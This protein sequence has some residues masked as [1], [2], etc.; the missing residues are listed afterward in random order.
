MLLRPKFFEKVSGQKYEAKYF[1]S[2][3]LK[4]TGKG[5]KKKEKKE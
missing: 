1:L 5:G 4:E 2:H 3:I